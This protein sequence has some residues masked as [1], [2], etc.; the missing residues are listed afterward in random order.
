MRLALLSLFVVAACGDGGGSVSSPDATTL[1][2]RWDAGDRVLQLTVSEPFR[3]PATPLPP[4]VPGACTTTVHFGEAMAAGA[5]PQTDAEGPCILTDAPAD[6]L[7]DLAA[8]RAVEGGTVRVDAR[9]PGEGAN[10]TLAGSFPPAAELPCETL[11][12]LFVVES[13]AGEIPDDPLGDFIVDVERGIRPS[14]STPDTTDAGIALWPATGDLRVVWAGRDSPSIEIRVTPRGGGS[15]TL[16][17]FVPDE[18]SF[19]LP[20]RLVDALRDQ[21]ATMEVI[22]VTG[23]PVAAGD[24]EVRI[25]TRTSD[26]I[27]LEP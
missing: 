3:D 20:S 16:Q 12:D 18:G 6:A 10:V 13:F 21:P 4:F 17:C 9:N 2:L 14:I 19:E 26:A 5:L 1:P 22:R 24:V 15:P 27:F 23:G 8:F 7:G 25:T 11:Q